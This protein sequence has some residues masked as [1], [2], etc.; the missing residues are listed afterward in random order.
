M[1]GRGHGLT[2]IGVVLVLIAS[3]PFAHSDVS[4]FLWVAHYFAN[5]EVN[6]YAAVFREKPELIGNVT[7][8][9]LTYWLLGAWM[10]LGHT[11][12]HLFVWLDDP[13]A[14]TELRWVRP[15]HVFWFR[16]LYLPF[17]L[18]LPV[19]TLRMLRA[20][21][22]E[23]SAKRGLT[24]FVLFQPIALW[25]TFMFGQFDIVPT[26]LAFGGVALM[27]EGSVLF[28][29]ALLALGTM[30]KNFPIAFLLIACGMKLV[31]TQRAGERARILTGLGAFAVVA[32]LLYFALAG[33]AFSRSFLA[34]NQHGRTLTKLVFSE[35]E[36]SVSAKAYAAIFIVV[37][38][39]TVPRLYDERLRVHVAALFKN[40]IRTETLNR[41]IFFLCTAAVSLIYVDRFWWAQYLCWL[42]P[43]ISTFVIIYSVESKN[44]RHFFAHLGFNVA[45]LVATLVM[46]SDQN[47]AIFR[48]EGVPAPGSRLS[49]I[50]SWLP[51]S[52]IS[53]Y[54]LIHVMLALHRAWRALHVEPVVLASPHD[55]ALARLGYTQAVLWLLFTVF[56]A[57]LSWKII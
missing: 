28:G 16:L 4:S 5:G 9:P 55:G 21:G 41:V 35:K 42:V 23:L 57:A 52:I 49:M 24:A 47:H 54:A 14:W 3:I 46:F 7:Y 56:Y 20:L 31:F 1:R 32:G 30:L 53:A 27:L 26:V 34:F 44:E 38:L 19:F 29:I 48:P 51:W 12:F 50:P 43:W 17:I 11:L 37:L 2:A 13:N 45:F 18:M 22:V 36:L 6:V 33:E 8:P 15:K 39:M 40:G 25:T 10:R